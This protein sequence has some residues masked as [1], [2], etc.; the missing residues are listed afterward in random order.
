MGALGRCTHGFEVAV[1][2]D[3]REPLSLLLRRVRLTGPQATNRRLA[4]LETAVAAL[5]GGGRPAQ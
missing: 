5:Q 1:W 3:A 4:S 2:R